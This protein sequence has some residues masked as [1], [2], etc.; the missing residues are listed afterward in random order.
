MGEALHPNGKKEKGENEKSCA[1]HLF[2]IDAFFFNKHYNS[3]VCHHLG[4]VAEW[5]LV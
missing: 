2:S 4:Y 3:T 5:G 1:P